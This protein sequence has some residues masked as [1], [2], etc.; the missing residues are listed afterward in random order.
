MNMRLVHE[1]GK[2]VYSTVP[3]FGRTGTGP[4]ALRCGGSGGSYGP[5]LGRTHTRPGGWH[6]GPAL[7]C[8]HN[9]PGAMY[10][11]VGPA[12]AHSHTGPRALHC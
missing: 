1:L 2:M 11:Q 10:R 9:R 12:L 7:D 6:V 4:R 5:V 8:T 3:V